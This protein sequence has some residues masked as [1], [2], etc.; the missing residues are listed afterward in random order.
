MEVA[1]HQT[2]INDLEN[3]LASPAAIDEA[4]AK[5]LRKQAESL[6]KDQLD[7][8]L[9]KD[10]EK[11]LAQMRERIHAQVEKREADYEKVLAELSTANAALAEENLQ[12]VED[13][14]HKALS[15]AGQI[16]GLSD[17][18]RAEIDKQLDKIYPK[19]RKLSA[20]RHWGT[21]RAREDLIDQIKQIIGSGMDPNKIVKHLRE[22]KQ[23]WQDWEK[24]GDHSEHKLWKEFSDSC[25][26]AYEPCREF[27]KAQK[28]ERKNNLA[29][30]R[31]LI[32][33]INQ[34]LE[35]TDWDKPDWKDIDKWLRQV[36]GKF[37]K[38]GH[39]DYKHHKK[40][41]AALETA[42]NSFE[43]HLSRE[44][45]RS[46][47]ARRKLV[48]DILALEQVDD[49]REAMSALDEL[50]KKWQITVLSKR[51]VENK[52][53]EKYQKAQDLIYSKRNAERKE[54]DQ[55]RNNNLKQKR[56]VVE[57]L[58]SAAAAK[59]VELLENSSALAQ[60]S[61]EF[62][63]I[64]YVPRKAEK[65]LMDNWRKAQKQFKTALADARKAKRKSAQSAL[66]EK[67]RLCSRLE[68][69]R[70]NGE[71]IDCDAAQQSY[72][73]LPALSA[74]LEKKL[75]ARLDAICADSLTSE[76]QIKANTTEQ[77]LRC[78]KLEVM[79]DLTTPEAYAKQRMAFQ[80]ERL[81][82]SMKKNTQAQEDAG[83]LK[84][85]LLSCG[86]IE[87]GQYEPIWQRIDAILNAA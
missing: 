31:Q 3:L 79:L 81:A 76:A 70:L 12:I 10:L 14:T 34:R 37:F 22:A 39:T 13:A 28:L 15:I 23:Q 19:M 77:L 2:L 41:K 32:A 33:D 26:K 30:K 5:P 71:S 85:Q 78:M 50:K 56:L 7:H 48:D 67:A 40:L 64:G 36:R 11:C 20:W 9:T 38:I 43:A 59:P 80:I 74:E 35:D 44:R 49:I 21:T 65:A 4:Q 55:E 27:F 1:V 47:K 83:D 75:R 68:Q 84:Q 52:L 66:L 24:S 82:A 63:A 62:N 51:G 58:L 29:E 87:A 61:D 60:C 54:Q 69:Q 6:L 42:L 46:L 17:Q 16:P 18:R 8:P 45:E 57:K 25:D 86:A 53:W 72:T 73:A